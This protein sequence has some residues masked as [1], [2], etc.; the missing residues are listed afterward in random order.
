MDILI[1]EQ[2]YYEDYKYHKPD[3]EARILEPCRLLWENG[4]VGEFIS[5]VIRERHPVDFPYDKINSITI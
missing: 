4:Y 3:F 1:H 5:D 2:Y